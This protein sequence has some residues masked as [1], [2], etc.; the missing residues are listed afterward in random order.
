MTTYQLDIPD[1]LWDGFK[2]TVSQSETLNDPIEVL[3][4]ERVASNDLVDDELQDRAE[5][6]L[7][8]DNH[9]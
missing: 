2:Q 6:Y 5:A 3:L 7:N 8:G 9:R 4:A 1:W